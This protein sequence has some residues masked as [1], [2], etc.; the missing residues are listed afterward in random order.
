MQ[1]E[2]PEQAQE[3]DKTKILNAP[4]IE[5]FSSIETARQ[6]W[7]EE[8]TKIPEFMEQIETRRLLNSRLDAIMSALPRPDVSLQ[9][10]MQNGTISEKQAAELYESLAAVIE[11]PDYQRAILYIPFEFLPND[12]GNV[13]PISE[14]LKSATSIFK[15]AYMKAWQNLL[16][17]QDVRANF[18][19]GDVLETE[20][21][22]GDL[23]RVV[24]AAHLIP[25]MVEKGFLTVDEILNLLAKA[26]DEVLRQ[27]IADTLPVLF[28]LGLLKEGNLAYI[29]SSDDPLL[30]NARDIIFASESE[31]KNKKDEP[32]E[33]N[34]LGPLAQTLESALGEIDNTPPDPAISVKRTKWLRQQQR[35]R[36]IQSLAR[37][38]AEGLV[39][40][41][42]NV[43]EV[44]Q[45]ILKK[46]SQPSKQ[47]LVLGILEATESLARED[48]SKARAIF[49]QY[50][51]VL[52]GLWQEED[53]QTNEYIAQA[54]RRLHGL[55]IAQDQHLASLNISIPDFTKPF[56]D[57]LAKMEKDR[58]AVRNLVLAIESNAELAAQ[59]YPAILMFGSKLKGYGEATADLD[60]AIFIKPGISPKNKERM[61]SLLNAVLP[62]APDDH[63]TEFWLKETEQGLAIDDQNLYDS[64][65]GASYWTHVLF[66]GAWEGDEQTIEMLRN[67][68]LVPYFFEQRK[69]VHG[70]EARGFY[71][72]E[73]ERDTLQYRFM[74]KG[75]KKFHPAMGGLDTPH[76]HLVDGESTFWDS[77]Y[78]MTAI[79][80]FAS[81]VFLPKL[82]ARGI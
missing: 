38:I 62:I 20:Y 75:Y 39:S 64:A 11:N 30:H 5:S 54:L 19:D 17:V 73:L 26:D 60:L 67:K 15:L 71:L 9:D 24:K 77:G 46:D 3:F 47:A 4:A 74:H 49:E 55:N 76:A 27:S 10:A 42:L 79:K 65:S 70:R 63:L 66:G 36:V 53:P 45:F 59:V 68:L 31:D 72:E 41:K 29:E 2:R 14:T 78:R 28:D 52:V 50:S 21:R 16:G 25:K 82:S 18:V 56:S 7:P 13:Q 8:V 32:T 33:K 58:L 69:K 43:D 34:A 48:E 6:V 44:R 57:H 22:N 35:T 81:R 51:D 40:Q 80:L 1:R 37:N 61:K 23:P 12:N